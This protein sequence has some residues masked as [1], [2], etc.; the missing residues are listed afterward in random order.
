MDT[1]TMR[2]I[3]EAQFRFGDLPCDVVEPENEPLFE[4][5]FKME[6]M[7]RIEQFM[8]LTPK[9]RSQYWCY[10]MDRIKE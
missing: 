6:P 9:V 3:L 5:M 4:S 7:D 10:M 8:A 2:T 1:M